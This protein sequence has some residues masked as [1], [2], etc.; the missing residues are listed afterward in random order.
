ML[1]TTDVLLKFEFLRKPAASQI[2]ALDWILSIFSLLMSNHHFYLSFLTIWE[3]ANIGQDR[4]GD[5]TR[6]GTRERTG[7]GIRDRTRDKKEDKT[8]DVTEDIQIS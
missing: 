2:P 7:H 4:T 3:T 1:T 8:R 5:R 6:D